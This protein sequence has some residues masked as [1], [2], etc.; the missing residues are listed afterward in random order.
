MWTSQ[1]PLD[2]AL[3]LDQS[4]VLGQNVTQSLD[5]SASR[6]WTGMKANIANILVNFPNGTDT[7]IVKLN[8]ALPVCI[9]P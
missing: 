2:G 4:K 8:T 7:S 1:N 5:Y 9:V 3:V 6:C